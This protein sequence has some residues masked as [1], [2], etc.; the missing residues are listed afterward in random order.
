MVELI[1]TEESYESV[2]LVLKESHVY[3]I[4]PLQS[5]GGHKA[6]D[7]DEAFL[8]TGRLR[9]ISKG[10][11]LYINLED[12]KT[13]ELFA[14]CHAVDEK[15]IEPVS[16]S[17]RYFVLKLY[18]EAS[19]SHAFVGLGFQDRNVRVLQTNILVRFRFQTVYTRLS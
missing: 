15:A 10:S 17:S 14:R 6:G 3:R 11:K 19:K 7:W 13:G 5:S 2:L 18:D 1:T 9:I 12:S 4:P 8:W 16:D